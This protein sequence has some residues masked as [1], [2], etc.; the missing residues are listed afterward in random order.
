MTCHEYVMH[1]RKTNVETFPLG[2]G[3]GGGG[4]QPINLSVTFPF[5]LL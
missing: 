2:G 4:V 3:G 5:L 1:R